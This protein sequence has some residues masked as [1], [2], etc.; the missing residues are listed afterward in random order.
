M[1]VHSDATVKEYHCSIC[2]IFKAKLPSKVK[3]H[4]EA[5]HFPGMFLYNCNICRKTFKGK[6]A[7]NIHKSTIHPKKARL[8]G[9]NPLTLHTSTSTLQ[10][11]IKQDDQSL[12]LIDAKLGIQNL[13][14]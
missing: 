13:M 9:V 6:N 14:E 7:L 3:N 12:G 1:D 11:T 5:I 8:P 4:L 10:K 2:N